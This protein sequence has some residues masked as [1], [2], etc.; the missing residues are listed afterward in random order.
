MEYRRLGKSGLPI[1]ELR[2]GSWITFGNQIENNTSERLMDIAYEAGVNFFDNAE[3]Y[4]A[5]ESEKVMGQILKKKNWSRDSYIVSS[6]VFF[7][8]GPKVPTQRGLNRKHI[9]EACNQALQRLQIE[10]ISIYISV[11]APTNK[12]PSKKPFG[13]C[14]NSSSLEKSSTGELP[15]GVRKKS[16]KHTWLPNA[17]TSSAP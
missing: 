5:G 6:K 3:V 1:S 14:T 15:N 16:W 4:A 10:T 12:H 11:T 9:V 8:A 13:R 17:I 2:F 7:G